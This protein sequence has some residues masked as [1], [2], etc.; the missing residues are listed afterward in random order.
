MSMYF[1]VGETFFY[2]KVIPH[3]PFQKILIFYKTVCII[4]RAVTPDIPKNADTPS[5]SI[6]TGINTFVKPEHKFTAVNAI[7]PESIDIKDARTGVF[8]PDI[9]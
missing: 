2:K 4:S 3:T 8:A 5:E 9:L 7:I 6:L 1:V